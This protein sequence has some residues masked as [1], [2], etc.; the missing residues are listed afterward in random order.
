M[1]NIDIKDIVNTM[2]NADSFS[3]FFVGDSIT[4]G[5]RASSDETTYVAYVAEARQIPLIDLHKAW[6]DHLV[7]GTENY[8]QQDWLSGV[9]GDSCHPSDIG[10]KAIA[11]TIL[12]SL[13]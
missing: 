3:I 9:V 4:E 7:I 6:M 13:K 8:G 12:D 5:T 10:H 1:R 2:D 11:Q